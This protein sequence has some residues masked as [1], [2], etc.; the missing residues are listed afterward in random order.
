VIK[1][2]LNL[3]VRVHDQASTTRLVACW[4]PRRAYFCVVGLIRI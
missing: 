1:I 4:V 2:C 3:R